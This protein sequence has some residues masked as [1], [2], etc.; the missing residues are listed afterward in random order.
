MQYTAV[1]VVSG[2]LDS[3]TMLYDTVEQYGPKN[4][5][6]LSF[7]YGQR[8]KVELEMATL[9]ADRLDIDSHVIDLTPINKLIGGSSLTDAI[10]VPEGH[11]A[12]ETMKQTVVPNR[13][14]I[15]SNVAI[16]ACVASGAQVLRLGIHAGDHPVY[17][18]C[19]P[20]FVF[21]LERLAHIANKGFIHPH[22]YIDCP[23]LNVEKSEIARRAHNLGLDFNETWSCYK[24]GDIHCGRCSTCVERL[25]AIALAQLM[26]ADKTEYADVNYWREVTGWAGDE[27]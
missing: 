21:A 12:W 7:D 23:F 24:G 19:R 3:T 9:A 4:T 15:M 26:H 25:E 20:E 16:G 10:E 18:D 11:Y 27:K 6:C 14:S 13:N 5:L 22:F 17:P 1:A 2:G 8:H